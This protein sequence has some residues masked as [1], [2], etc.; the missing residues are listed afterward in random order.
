MTLRLSVLF[1]VTTALTFSA[2]APAQNVQFGA[3]IQVGERFKHIPARPVPRRPDGRVILGGLPG[4]TGVWMPFNGAPERVV[5]PDNLSAEAAAQFPDRPRL[6]DVPFQPW[7][8]ALHA[9]RAANQFEP[10]TRCKPS[11]GPRQFL[12]PYGVHFLEVPE[13]QR[14]FILD[15]G[16][17]QSFRTIHMD[18]KSHPRNLVP[19]Y[20]GHSIGH[21]EGDTL[22]VDTRGFKE[23]FWFDRSGLPHT[24]QL[25]LI[26]R[27]TRTDSKTMKYQVTVDDPGAYTAIWSGGFLMGWNPEQD[28]FEYV[29]QENNLASGLMLGS[30]E[31]VDRTSPIVP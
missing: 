29:C 6:S 3:P 30:Q 31:F 27:F 2:A 7:A 10:H 17:P 19:S 15:Q 8:R 16:G 25:H 1:A 26:E 12:T 21:W 20:Y 4:E 22:V 13:L 23:A 24:S 28:L 18:V 5:N 14:I 9:F 11:G